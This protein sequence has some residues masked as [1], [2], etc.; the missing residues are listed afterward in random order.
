MLAEFLPLFVRRDFFASCL[1]GKS[2]TASVHT[3]GCTASKHGHSSLLGGVLHRSRLERWRVTN[4]SIH[5]EIVSSSVRANWNEALEGEEYPLGDVNDEEMPNVSPLSLPSPLPWRSR[6]RVRDNN[7]P[8]TCLQL[9][10]NCSGRNVCPP[11]I[12]TTRSLLRF[13]GRNGFV[14]GKRCHQLLLA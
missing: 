8:G 1:L 5:G 13:Q 10:A 9:F 7:V 11:R 12:I 6:A 4:D 2:T 14:H 3:L